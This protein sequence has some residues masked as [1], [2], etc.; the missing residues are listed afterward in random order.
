MARST[1]GRGSIWRCA[2]SALEGARASR[3]LQVRSIR[4]HPSLLSTSVFHDRLGNQGEAVM[5]DYFSNDAR[6]RQHRNAFVPNESHDHAQAVPGKHTLTT[7]PACDESAAARAHLPAAQ[8]SVP[9]Q[10]KLADEQR[11]YPD[12]DARN[13]M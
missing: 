9:V 7:S 10:R 12:L 8:D 5:S 13:R 3:R 4:F 2:G 1:T 11:P 6:G